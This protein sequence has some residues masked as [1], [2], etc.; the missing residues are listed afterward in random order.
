VHRHSLSVVVLCVALVCTGNAFA[1]KLLAPYASLTTHAALL[2]AQAALA[3]CQKEGFTVAVAVVD[4][5]GHALVLLRDNLAGAHTVQTAINTAATAVSFRMETAELAASTQPGKEGSGI[6]TL[7]NVVAIG[8][9]LPIQA[10]GTQVGGIGVSGA[11]GGDADAMCARAGIA[12][13]R[14]ALELE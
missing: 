8:G 5:G 7:P 14:D 1:Q 3:R 12:A 13:I 10:K 6:R 4:R 2:A 9:G 11:P